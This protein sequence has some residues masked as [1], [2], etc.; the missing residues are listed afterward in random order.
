MLLLVPLAT[1]NINGYDNLNRQSLAETS[2][3][4]S[5]KGV[6]PGHFK[7]LKEANGIGD[8]EYCTLVFGINL[9]LTT[10]K[11]WLTYK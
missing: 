10:V 9:F 11:M 2:R 3:A 5:R 1:I 7:A 4:R 8:G 6:I